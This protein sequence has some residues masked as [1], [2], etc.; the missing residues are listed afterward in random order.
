MAAAQPATAP[1][2]VPGATLTNAAVRPC[3]YK[4]GKVLGE[5]TYAKVKEAFHVTTGK[6]YAVKIFNKQL[7]HGREHM[8]LNEINILKQVSSG[9]RNLVSLVDYFESANNLYLVTE[10]CRGGEL[11]YRI[12]QKGHYTERDAAQLVRTIVSAVAYLHEKGIVHRDLKPENL[13]FKTPDD[14]SDLLIADFGLARCLESDAFPLLTTT[15]GTPGYMAPEILQ[16]QSYGKSVDMWAI[17]VITYFLLSGYQPFDRDTTAAEIQAIISADYAFEPKEYWTGVSEV[18]KDFIRRLLKIEPSERMSAKQALEHPWL[19]MTTH[20]KTAA[21]VATPTPATAP[22]ADQSN[23]LPKIR[24]HSRA[25]SQARLRRAFRA[26]NVAKMWSRLGS[27]HHLH[28]SKD[29]TSIEEDVPK[30]VEEK[31]EGVTKPEASQYPMDVDAPA[32][33][34]EHGDAS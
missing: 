22:G 14:D 4:V 28:K 19:D 10:V 27:E 6:P 1:T 16:R 5:G 11:F 12:C 21:G 25:A 23:L 32:A 29:T 7:M 17:G 2:P 20:D 24:E 26:I 33:A 13:L 18:A 30:P 9:H 31:L 34:G 15:C 8:V 3:E